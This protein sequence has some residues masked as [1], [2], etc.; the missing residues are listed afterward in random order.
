MD[1]YNPF[2]CIKQFIIILH[3]IIG[4]DIF[5]YDDTLH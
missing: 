1:N 4:I 3:N 2:L 5:L